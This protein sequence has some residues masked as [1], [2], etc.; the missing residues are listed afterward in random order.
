MGLSLVHRCNPVLALYLLL[1]LGAAYGLPFVRVAPNRLVSG[2][3]VF[4]SDAL[5]H[6]NGQL[7]VP[8]LLA[9]FTLL[10]VA[11]LQPRKRITQ[12]L[13]FLAMAA[14]LACLWLLAGHIANNA[15]ETQNSFARTA[16]GAGFWALG[17]LAWLIGIDAADRL[18]LTTLPR[19]LLQIAL[20]LP[21][22]LSLSQGLNLSIAQEYANHS[23]VFGPAILRHLQ[24]VMLA[25]APALVIGLLLAWRMSKNRELRQAIFPVLNVLQTIPSIALFGLL[26]A[27]LAWIAL[28]WPALSRA[29]IGGVGI[30]PAVLALLMYALLPIARSALA[31]L[32]QV[33]A[34]AVNAARAMG[35]SSRQIL[36][37]VELPLALPALFIGLRTAV[38][39]TTGL[40][41]VSA[42]VGAGG[43]GQIMFDGLFSAANELVILG[44]I[45]IV[46]LAMLADTAFKL[47]GSLFWTSP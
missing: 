47:L 7:I 1:A 12:V 21:L 17:A 29:G 11:A 13:V 41:A 36:W 3:P 18:Q 44:V 5:L 27:P 30:A 32:E 26:M 33:P 24:I 35:M 28:Q 39:Q 22:L 34:E 25:V 23:D 15:I 40:A 6:L 31:G 42:L 9:L 20:L 10:S 16:L 14:A 4:L 37:E 43:L 45:P 8:L 19:L 46:L 2:E 38:V